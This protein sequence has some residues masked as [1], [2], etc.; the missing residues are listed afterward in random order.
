MLRLKPILI[1]LCLSLGLA[2]PAHGAIIV[3]TFQGQITSGTDF[4]GLF[5]GTPGG[6]DELSS[7]DGGDGPGVISGRFSYDST[8]VDDGAGNYGGD[9]F[10]WLG[11][12]VTIAGTSYTFG[13]LADPDYNF[14]SA[15]VS[16][17]P[18]VFN[19]LFEQNAPSG[20]EVISIGLSMEDFLTGPGLPE[21]FDY[22]GFGSGVGSL[23][24]HNGI[25][26]AT[27]DFTITSVHAGVVPEPATWMMLILGFGFVGGALRRA[28]RGS[29]E[30]ALPSPDRSVAA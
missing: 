14:Q 5:T 1:A 25:D 9:G 18:D 28:R 10:N 22:A 4:L 27:A 16:D 30:A 23:T 3:G 11:L 26:G 7:F 12:E 24:I 19:L 15:A 2:A 21:S 29:L 8:M 6:G 17:E 20:G 13:G